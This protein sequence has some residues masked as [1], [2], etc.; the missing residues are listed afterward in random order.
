MNVQSK[1]TVID[2]NAFLHQDHVIKIKAWVFFFWKNNFFLSL[3][4]SFRSYNQILYIKKIFS[5]DFY[6]NTK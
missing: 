1:V 2:P 4:M 3:I 5:V 6:Y